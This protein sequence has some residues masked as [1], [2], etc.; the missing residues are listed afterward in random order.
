[1]YSRNMYSQLA[2]NLQ[3]GDA[4]RQVFESEGSSKGDIRTLRAACR[5]TDISASNSVKSA[6]A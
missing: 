1:V 5:M 4:R 3:A 2:R 6:L